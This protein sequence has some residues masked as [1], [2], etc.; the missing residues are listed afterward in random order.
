M[1]VKYGFF[2]SVNGDRK[3][4][5]DDISNFFLKLVSNGVFASP[6]TNLKVSASG[7]MTVSVAAGWA[8]ISCKYLHNT[9]AYSVTLDAS[10]ASLDRI[11]RIVLRVNSST[12]TVSIEYVKGTAAANPTPPPLTRV[13]EGLWEL[14]LAQI[15]VAANV[16][17]ITSGNITDERA[18]SSVCGYITGLITQLD[19]ATIFGG[20]SFRLCTNEAEYEAINPKVSTV[21]Y[22]VPSNSNFSLYL[23]EKSLSGGTFNVGRAVGINGGISSSVIGKAEEETQ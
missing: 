18:D 19:T 6:D 22:A 1:A 12:R 2:N 20:M 17:E 16:S 13:N 14:S 21:L 23:G 8:M 10:H 5:A 4:N 3:Y 11:D 9:T 7:E 15:Y